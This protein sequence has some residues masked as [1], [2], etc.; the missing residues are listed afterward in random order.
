M[1]ISTQSNKSV[2]MGNGATTTFNY[3]FLMPLATDAVIT[4][5]MVD[6]TQVP[7][8]ASLYIITG[9]GN[10]TGGTVTYPISGTPIPV[11][12]TLTIERILPYVQETTISNQGAFYPK[13]V[14]AALDYLMMCIQQLANLVGQLEAQ[15]VA[16]AGDTPIPPLTP[17]AI[18]VKQ[19]KLQLIAIA[20]MTSV[21][22]AILADINQ[23]ENVQWFTGGNTS[24]G[25]ALSQRIQTVLGY[26]DDQMVAFYAAA[27]SQAQ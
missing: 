23:E 16:L 11:G 12:S 18:N 9:I 7:I 26:T 15:I 10:P 27:A 20:Q 6:G 14:E 19:I 25:D 2:G 4:Y 21:S 1:T 17:A 5:T 24:V 8:A 3:A 22:N 13:V